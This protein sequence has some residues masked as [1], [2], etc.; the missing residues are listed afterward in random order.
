MPANEGTGRPAGSV[1]SSGGHCGPARKPI[2]FQPGRHKPISAYLSLSQPISAYRVVSLHGD[3]LSTD[4]GSVTRGRLY[5]PHPST[6][7]HNGAK[8]PGWTQPLP[9]PPLHSESR[10]AGPGSPPHHPARSR[11]QVPPNRGTHLMGG[12]F[13][14]K[15]PQKKPR[16]TT[17]LG[18]F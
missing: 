7:A 14:L 9:S 4:A 15:S 17:K 2:G 8:T 18:T 10:E 11:F 12:F 3:S 5:L 16:P 1:G 13:R 6:Q